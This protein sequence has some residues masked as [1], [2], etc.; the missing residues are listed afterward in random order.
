MMIIKLSKIL[1]NVNITKTRIPSYSD[2]DKNGKQDFGCK[3][4]AKNGSETC[5]D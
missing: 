2:L 3:E 4:N 1:S 5:T